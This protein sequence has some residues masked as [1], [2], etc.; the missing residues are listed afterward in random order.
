[1]RIKASAL[2][3]SYRR[4][5]TRTGPVPPP[6]LTN[7]LQP[8]DWERNMAAVSPSP[9]EILCLP[10]GAYVARLQGLLYC[11]RRIPWSKILHFTLFSGGI[12]AA[13]Q[14]HD[15]SRDTFGFSCGSDCAGF[16]SIR[17]RGLYTV[18]IAPLGVFP[19][20]GDRATVLHVLPGFGDSPRGRGKARVCRPG[21]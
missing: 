19:D 8:R 20:F 11:R 13:R 12:N 17:A 6:P 1:M 16:I 7:G 5:T 10:P 21:H 15:G 2:P 18:M 4:P 9:S 3:G 14:R